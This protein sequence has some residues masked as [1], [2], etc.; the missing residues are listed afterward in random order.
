[1]RVLVTRPAR[2]AVHWV[3]GLA[4]L[5]F[6]VQALPLIDI[7][8]PPEVAPLAVARQGLGSYAAVMFVSGN[9]VRGLLGASAGLKAMEPA[10][11]VRTI[12][13]AR[14]WSPGPGTTGVLEQAGWPVWAIDAPAHDA[15]QFD[16][17][18]LWSQVEPQAK[19]GQRVLIV[20]GADVQGRV[21]GRDWLAAKLRAAGVMVEEVA[22]YCRA[23]PT[24]DPVQHHLAESATADGSVWLFSSSEAI[25]NLQRLL[26]ARDW[27]AARAIATHERIDQAARKAGFGQVMQARPTLEAVAASI[28]SLS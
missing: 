10:D 11:V 24:L 18:A 26:P 6:D 27:S 16:S 7:A 15:P 2:E 14:A 4:A 21:A 20:R 13:R 23:L 8:P 12:A 25:A 17:E 9:A 22:A 3:Q 28:E 5:G 19:E 1:M